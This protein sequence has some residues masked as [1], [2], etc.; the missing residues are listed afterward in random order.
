M[1]LKSKI[2]F[3]QVAQTI[4]YEV[5][6]KLKKRNHSSKRIQSSNLRD[7]K[8]GADLESER[9]IIKYLRKNSNFSILSE[10]SGELN[11]MVRSDFESRIRWIVDPLDGSLNYTKGIPICGI[12]IGLWEE[13]TPILGVVYDIFREDMY[14]GIVGKAAWR[15]Q[16]KIQVSNY[17]L[18]S[19]SVLCTGIPI[20]NNFSAKN[21]NSFVSKFQ[22]YKKVRLF[23][24]ASLSLCMVACGAAEVYQENNI[25]IWDVGGGIPVVMG[26]GGKV[27]FHKT[28]VS[29]YTYDV[30]ATNGAIRD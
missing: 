26:A 27:V 3:L 13:E 23:G 15:N 19:D 18:K 7:V 2:Q 12:S 5:G 20:K 29:P 21:L 24:S 11:G 17:Y 16:K 4:S 6:Q 10:E 28:S 9:K 14:S 1:N 8:I 25:Q 30:K 22:H